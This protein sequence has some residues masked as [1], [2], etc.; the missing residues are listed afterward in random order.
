MWSQKTKIREQLN[1]YTAELLRT[2]WKFQT[3][4]IAQQILYEHNVF[5]NTTKLCT[6]LSTWK[7]YSKGI[8]RF[9]DI[10][11]VLGTKPFKKH[12]SYHGQQKT[13]G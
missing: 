5:G 10:I 12:V 7:L 11:Q 13:K 1:S 6:L 9:A 4:T 8:C 2:A 3:I